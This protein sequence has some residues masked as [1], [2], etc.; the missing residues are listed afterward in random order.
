MN[1]KLKI[2]KIVYTRWHK[3]PLSSPE[4]I[5][6]EDKIGLMCVACTSKLTRE[7]LIDLY[8]IFLFI[9]LIVAI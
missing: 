9:D 6:P 4:F 2:R 3:Q 5:P 7:S 8:C 1:V